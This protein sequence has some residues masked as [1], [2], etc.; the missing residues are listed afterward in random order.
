MIK[1]NLFF[2]KYDCLKKKYLKVFLK[3]K[4]IYKKDFK[5]LFKFFNYDV[6]FEDCMF[7]LFCDCLIYQVREKYWC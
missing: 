1:L 5:I 4:K 6:I 2:R 7:D 3:L